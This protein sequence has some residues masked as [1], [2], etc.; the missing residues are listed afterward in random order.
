[1]NTDGKKHKIVL[2]MRFYNRET[3][4]P[5]LSLIKLKIQTIKTLKYKKSILN[6]SKKKKDSMY[7]QWRKN[8]KGV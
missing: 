3:L 4:S 8:S 2:I 7:V 6:K 5:P 1:M